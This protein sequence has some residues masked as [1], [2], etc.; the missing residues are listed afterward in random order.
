MTTEHKLSDEVQEYQRSVLTELIKRHV[1]LTDEQLGGALGCDAQEVTYVRN[2]VH[3]STIDAI[4]TPITWDYVIAFNVGAEEKEFINPKDKTQTMPL[5]QYNGQIFYDFKQRLENAR[6]SVREYRSSDNEKMFLIIG[7]TEKN[8]KQWADDRDTD[9]ITDPKGAVLAGRDKTFPLANRTRLD[10]NEDEKTH[11][12]SMENWKD[13][14]VQYNPRADIKIYKRHQRVRG[15]DDQMTIFDEKTRLRIIYEAIVADQNEGGA[16]IKIENFLFNKKHPLIAV[17]PLHDAQVQDH[18]EKIWRK[19]ICPPKVLFWAPLDEVRDYFGEPVGFYFAFLQFYLRWLLAPAVVGII[20]FTIQLISGTIDAP[21]VFICSFFI[22]FWSVAFVDFWARQEARFRLR[23]GMT[24]FQQKAVARPQFNG[25]WKHDAVTGLWAEQYS[26]IARGCKMTSIFSGVFFY[27]LIVVTFVIFVLSG[28]D[29][30]PDNTLLKI[31]Y[32][33]LNGVM[34]FIFDFVYKRLAHL[35]NE[36]ENHRTQQDYENALIQ[37]SFFFKFF[38]SFSTLFYLAFVRPSVL[39]TYYYLRYYSGVNDS[40]SE[41]CFCEDTYVV[42]AYCNQVCDASSCTGAAS[43]YSTYTDCTTNADVTADAPAG[44]ELSNDEWAYCVTGYDTY[45]GSSVAATCPDTDGGV[46]LQVLVNE[47][48]MSDLRVQL[49]TLF[50]SAIIIQNSLEV[51]IPFLVDYIKDCTRE[52]K[53]LKAGGEVLERSEPEE[54]M[55]F[56]PYLNTID[57]MAELMVQFGYVTLFVM[58][59][60]ITPVLAILNNVFEMKVDAHNLIRQSQ[61]PHPNGSYGLGTW[62]SV[63]QLFSLAAVGTNVALIV[64]RTELVTTVVAIIV[65]FQDDDDDTDANTYKW[66]FFS[67][68]SVIIAVIV[69]VEKYLIP[70]VPLAVESAIERQTLVEAV[71]VLGA[72]IDNDNDE[73]PDQGED[74]IFPFDSNLTSVDVSSLKLI[75]PTNLHLGGDATDDAVQVVSSSAGGGDAGDAGQTGTTDEYK[76]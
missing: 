54:Q 30:A 66:I 49:T 33:V 11:T 62:N 28:K 56:A 9:L 19:P 65:S 6:L 46:E 70:D 32:G 20:F 44:C 47:Q 26:F 39:G 48:I 60:P 14:Y 17:F 58:A 23:W 12:I 57:D 35:G 69:A 4:D 15:K 40:G 72:N 37:K 2:T 55:D 31:A 64:W 42:D 13:L 50:L 68:M 76:E 24:K 7:L 8:L 10:E 73:P 16:E 74:D 29:S 38:N 25:E 43:C 52:K 36:W 53:Q 34:I 75:P 22:I 41:S 5:R 21:G 1:N 67:V 71:L 3:R 27:L 59:L 61:R 45:G 63:L 18:L 51:G